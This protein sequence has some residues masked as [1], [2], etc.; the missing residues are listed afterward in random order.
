[1]VEL[2]SAPSAARPVR[3]ARPGELIRLPAGG[4]LRL[5]APV[6]A[7]AADGVRMWRAVSE[8][9][10][11][12]AGLLAEFGRPIGYGYLAR[13][14]PLADYQTVFATP[15]RDADDPVKGA[16]A[17]MPSA[18]RPFTTRLVTDLVSAGVL[19]A[20]V[21]LHCGVSS[22]EGGEAPLAERF[23]V[24]ARTAMLA[25][26]V[27]AGGGRVIAVG[28]TVTRALESAARGDGQVTAAQGWT[29]LVLGPDRPVTVVDGLITGLH[30]PQASHL[31]LL[32]ALAGRRLLQRVYDAAVD[33]RYL[34][35]EFGDA[36]LL[37]PPT[38]ITTDPPWRRSLSVRPE[39]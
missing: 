38:R 6:G 15:P 5:D 31:L 39:S 18:G 3:D 25:N 16:S 1:V 30:D 37:L 21:Q 12:A 29:E 19:I 10:P 36:C 33:E 26:W 4:R 27:R 22:L 32:A 13:Q 11:D 20:P 24:P 28:T 9:T 23:R 17:E 7:P 8:C 34:W 14:W 2:R 35:H